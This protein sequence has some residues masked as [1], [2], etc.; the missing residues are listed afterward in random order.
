MKKI[1][2]LTVIFVMTFFVTACGSEERTAPAA[3]IKILAD[4]FLHGDEVSLKKINM[5]PEEYD[6]QFVA[7][8][9]KSFTESSGI[10]FTP[11][12]IQKVNDAMRNLFL[13]STCETA[14]VEVKG[15]NATVKITVST[16]TPFDEN[17]VLAKLPE[18]I[19]TLDETERNDALAN[20]LTE[21]LNEWQYSG[22]AEFNVE[23]A[24]NKQ[25]KF[26]LP[27]ESENFG[28]TIAKKVFNVQ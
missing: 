20:A 11:E 25:H 17:A 4:A 21:I 6:K 23:C 12:Q 13:R 7:E 3:D 28:E 5:T 16:L 1:F 22:T 14:D 19:A 26:W 18:N 10:T 9:A 15:D 8:F 27:V 24:Y 2:A